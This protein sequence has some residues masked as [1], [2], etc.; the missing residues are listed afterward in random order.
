MGR[1]KTTGRY[2]TRDEL[3]SEVWRMWKET[4]LNMTEVSKQARVS[5][6]TVSSILDRLEG[7]DAVSEM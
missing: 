3:V 6:G 2:N 5:L 4:P 7:L 1:K